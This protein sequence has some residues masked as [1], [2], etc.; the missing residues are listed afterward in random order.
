M[1]RRIITILCLIISV[2]AFATSVD[3]GVTLF[4]QMHY[5]QAQAV[6]EP[7]AKQ[8]D[9]R[10]MFWLG[11]SQFRTGEQFKAGH[12]LLKSAEAGNPWA[13]LMMSPEDNGYCGYLGWPCDQSWRDKAFSVLEKLADQGNGNAICTLLYRKGKPWWTYVPILNKQRGGELAEKGVKNGWYRMAN[14]GIPMNIEKQVEL[15]RYAANQN[16]APAMIELYSLNEKNTDKAKG[17]EN[18]LHQAVKLGYRGG[19][20]A[21]YYYYQEKIP[22]LESV[23]D[24][25]QL[26][27]DEK[28]LFKKVYYYSLIASGYGSKKDYLTWQWV[29]DEKDERVTITLISS[30][31]EKEIKK[32][33]K[34]FLRKFKPNLFLDESSDI[35]TLLN[36]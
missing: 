3:E 16:Y 18:L 29:K 2:N 35:N 19:A 15:L 31:E 8:G 7:L 12:T 20:L 9:A 6:F 26:T 28:D 32:K 4:N 5:K 14:C 10:A 1:I 30:Y 11:V 17:S 24:F 34:L 21:F 22:D 13:M 33:A 25:N 23:S 27:S 36:P